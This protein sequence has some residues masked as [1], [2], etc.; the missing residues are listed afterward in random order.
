MRNKKTSHTNDGR[1]G[2]GWN[3]INIFYQCLCKLYDK[4]NRTMFLYWSQPV[5]KVA[6][7]SAEKNENFSRSGKSQGIFL[8]SSEKSGNSVFRF[9]IH[10]FSSRLWDAFSFGKDEKYAAKQAKRSI[11]HSTPYSCSSCGHWF[12]LWMLSSKFLHPLSAKIGK[13]LKMKKK[14]SMAYKKS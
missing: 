4:V 10:K 1:A 11:S 9:I 5:S 8:K 2:R 7:V 3:F 6:T 13:R 14:T 12:S